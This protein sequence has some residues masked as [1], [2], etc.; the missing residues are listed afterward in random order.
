MNIFRVRPAD[1]Q[2]PCRFGL[3]DNGWLH[4]EQ[5][6]I[7]RAHAGQYTDVLSRKT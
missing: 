3:S 7:D 6:N 4:Q 2:A 1:R 5:A